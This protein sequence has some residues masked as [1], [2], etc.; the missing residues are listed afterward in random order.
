MIF[1]RLQ[2]TGS[3]RVRADAPAR[4]WRCYRRVRRVEGFAGS[5]GRAQATP[6][7]VF[8]PLVSRCVK[9]FT[10]NCAARLRAFAGPGT[11]PPFNTGWV[12]KRA[13]ART[14]H[15]L[16]LLVGGA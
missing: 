9:L 3:P 12:L 2:D 15:R 10:S 16:L 11:A 7:F 13:P 8:P 5:D 14:R 1:P 6:G 4:R